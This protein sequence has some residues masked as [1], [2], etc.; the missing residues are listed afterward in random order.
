MN[1]MHPSKILIKI[2]T[3]LIYNSNLTNMDI[4][5]HNMISIKAEK[6]S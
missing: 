6:I 5:S 2:N 1:M 3:Q 4:V